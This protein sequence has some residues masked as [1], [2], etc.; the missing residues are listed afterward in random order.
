[1][2][3]IVGVIHIISAQVA[4]LFP[5]NHD[6]GNRAYIDDSTILNFLLYSK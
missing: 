1:M 5:L 4:K 2:Q 6:T 3:K